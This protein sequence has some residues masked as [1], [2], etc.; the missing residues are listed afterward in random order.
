MNEPGKTN[1]KAST[2]RCIS[3]G[4]CC[5]DFPYI[6]LSQDEIEAIESF[7][8]LAPEAFSNDERNGGRRFMKFKE[9]GDCVF[10]DLTEGAYTCRVY[11]ARPGICSG[12]PTNEIQDRTCRKNSDR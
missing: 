7:T 3:C 4:T 12:Y 2:H 6:Q 8:G 5:R 10:L 1:E 11:E 9:D